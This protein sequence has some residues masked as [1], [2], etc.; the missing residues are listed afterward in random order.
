MTTKTTA[1]IQD[2]ASQD[3]FTGQAYFGTSRVIHMGNSRIVPADDG[4][5]ILADGL[6]FSDAKKLRLK[7]TWLVQAFSIC[8]RTLIF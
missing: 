8:Y 5:S 3:V 7:H 1:Y 4:A 2:P 6:G